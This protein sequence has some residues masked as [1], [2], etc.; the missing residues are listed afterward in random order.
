MRA[1]R[2]RHAARL[3]LAIV[4]LIAAGCQSSPPVE[5]SEILNHGLCKTLRK[6]LTVVDYDRLADIRGARMLNARQADPE[7]GSESATGT[8]LAVS[9]GSQPTPGYA[10]ELREARADGTHLVLD[11]TWREPP[12]D[13]VLAQV[14]TSP[15][16][17]VR[18]FN[19]GSARSVAAL[20][21]GAEIGRVDLQNSAAQ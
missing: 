3:L 2:Q 15:C 4:P 8:L 13:A 9:N 12:P 20:L 7:P 17:V 16:S 11:Y 14:V 1:D 19:A 6:G 18:I 21:D 5:V 10:F